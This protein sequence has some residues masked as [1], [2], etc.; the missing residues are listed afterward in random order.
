[1][2]T[3]PSRDAMVSPYSSRSSKYFGTLKYTQMMFAGS[4]EALI[5]NIQSRSNDAVIVPPVSGPSDA[6]RPPTLIR[7]AVR[8]GRLLACCVNCDRGQ[9]KGKPFHT[10]PVPNPCCRS[11]GD[12]R[13]VPAVSDRRSISSRSWPP[14]PWRDG[15]YGSTMQGCVRPPSA[16]E[17]RE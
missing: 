15:G 5:R 11:H 1:M 16:A 12:P 6:T 17:S 4:N 3:A 2:R 10:A 14:N 7:S 8:I 13:V 9:R